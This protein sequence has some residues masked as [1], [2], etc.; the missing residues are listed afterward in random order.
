MKRLTPIL[1]AALMLVSCRQ[2]ESAETP[3]DASNP[4]EMA[5]REANL[6]ED[7]DSSPATGLYERRHSSGRD[8]LCIVPAGLGGYRFGLIASFGTELK[9]QGHGSATQS[10]DQLT[11]DFDDADC[12]VEAT[13]DGR[14]IQLA[15]AVP[16]SCA[17]ICGPRASVSG[18]SVSRVG[19]QEAD[20]MTLRSRAKADEGQPLCRR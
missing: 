2:R 17:E 7:P 6:V 4:I 11:L 19:W 1:V 16:E 14:T 9:C 3:I 10:G 18:V 15:G 12:E 13:Y 8:A 5:A 20:A